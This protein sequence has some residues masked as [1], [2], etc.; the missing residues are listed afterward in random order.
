VSDLGLEIPHDILRVGKRAFRPFARR[1][2]GGQSGLG[3]L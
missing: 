3:S 1:C 2:F